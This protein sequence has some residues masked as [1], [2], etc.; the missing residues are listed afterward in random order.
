MFVPLGA[1][2]LSVDGASTAWVSESDFELVRLEAVAIRT[3]K[4]GLGKIVRQTQIR[5]QQLPEVH[6]GYTG[7]FRSASSQTVD[8]RRSSVARALA[9]VL[10]FAS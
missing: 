7:E 6:G 1:I 4:L 8:A 3:V 9:G 5:V 2:D 10:M